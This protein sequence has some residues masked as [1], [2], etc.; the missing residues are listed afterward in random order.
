[1]RNENDIWK[2]LGGYIL[3]NRKQ[4]IYFLDSG[5]YAKLPHN[6]TLGQVNGA[7]A[8]NLDNPRFMTDFVNLIYSDGYYTTEGYYNQT[9][10]PVDIAVAISEV[11]TTVSSAIQEAKMY[12]FQR[13]QSLRFEERGKE[14]DKWSQE[15]SEIQAR[16]EM[17]LKLQ[18]SQQKLILERQVQSERTKNITNFMIFGI[19]IVGALGLTF[20]VV[21]MNKSKAK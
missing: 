18:E 7:V 9:G 2:L 13:L 21:K 8:D 20:M 19:F 6:A 14:W 3:D 12:T 17:S 1:M 16:K 15:Q 4:V 11:I 5:G 10:T